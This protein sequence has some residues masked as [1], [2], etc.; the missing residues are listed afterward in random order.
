MNEAQKTPS[1]SSTTSSA[2]QHASTSY[3]YGS[4]NA[5]GRGSRHD[6]SY[7][8]QAPGM[9]D[10]AQHS[11][12]RAATTVKRTF[13]DNPTLALAGVVAFGA[14]AMLLL[15]SRSGRP[16]TSMQR[17]QRTL[18]RQARSIRRAVRQEMRSSGLASRMDQIGS[19]L[20]SIDLK[21][22]LQPILEQAAE[23]AGKAKTRLSNAAK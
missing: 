11:I 7:A 22:Y 15:R 14:V 16:E 8:G 5:Y 10:Q 6:R 9:L 19:G 17:M 13:Q 23:M 1:T 2:G 12:D 3:G 20:S 4:D 21:P 18:D